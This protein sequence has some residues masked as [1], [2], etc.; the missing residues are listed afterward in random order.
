VPQNAQSDRL[1]TS[2][3][4]NGDLGQHLRS[5][6]TPS[7]DWAAIG[8][9]ASAQLHP[10]LSYGLRDM[11][12][13][14]V[15]V[16]NQSPYH[17]R[18]PNSLFPRVKQ[19]RQPAPV[20]QNPAQTRIYLDVFLDNVQKCLPILSI[21]DLEVY[22][23]TGHEDVTA[24]GSPITRMTLA[25]GAMLRPGGDPVSNYHAVQLLEGALHDVGMVETDAQTLRLFILVT[26]FSLFHSAA[27]S[28]WHLLGLTVQVAVALGLNHRQTGRAQ[29]LQTPEDS[30]RDGLFWTVYIL[31]R[32]E[33]PHNLLQML[34]PPLASI[35]RPLDSSPYPLAG[36]WASTMRISALKYV[37]CHCL[38]L[39]KLSAMW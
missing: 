35:D 24:A 36:R 19:P 29:T 17:S 10:L 38:L 23:S 33:N 28:T 30:E 31:D 39:C 7:V 27:G 14:A 32:Y 26:L 13:S 25:L 1:S 5:G 2:S 16:G 9:G 12:L 6:P 20:F 34:P 21:A 11:F 18:Q 3:A 37:S 22:T 15:A 8:E 4:Q